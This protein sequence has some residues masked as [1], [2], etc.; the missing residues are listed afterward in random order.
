MFKHKYKFTM[1][2]LLVACLVLSLFLCFVNR[3]ETTA[4]DTVS[5]A[6]SDIIEPATNDEK[7]A[8]VHVEVVD[9]RDIDLRKGSYILTTYV[10]IHYNPLEILQQPDFMIENAA[11]LEKRLIKHEVAAN[12]QINDVYYLVSVHSFVPII[13]NYPLD[14]QVLTFDM[15]SKNPYDTYSFKINSWMLSTNIY[16]DSYTL[17]KTGTSLQMAIIDIGNNEFFTTYKARG[18]IVIEHKSFLFYLRSFQMMLVS[19]IIALISFL[20]ISD[21]A[22]FSA[23][24]GALLISMGNITN[25]FSKVR[26]GQVVTLLDVSSLYYILVIV[27]VLII[28]SVNSRNRYNL[29]KIEKRLERARDLSEEK[30]ATLSSEKEDLD[31]LIKKMDFYAIISLNI[32]IWGYFF[33]VYLLLRQ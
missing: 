11:I 22:R 6:T 23:I 18:Y 14:S 29:D 15:I 17:K 24:I 2:F 1:A 5:V 13:L 32:M 7:F 10:N 8:E 31:I 33:G 21:N 28:V 4:Q 27:S 9:I 16:L 20:S 25:L 12:G 26:D 30:I 19:V 3:L